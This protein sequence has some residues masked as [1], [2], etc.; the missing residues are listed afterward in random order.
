MLLMLQ[1]YRTSLFVGGSFMF[2][3]KIKI[4]LSGEDGWRNPLARGL[5]L[6]LSYGDSKDF[7]PMDCSRDCVPCQQAI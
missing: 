5:I 4:L 7:N 6:R 1:Q 2:G 3:V